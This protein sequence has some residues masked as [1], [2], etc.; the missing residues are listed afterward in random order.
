MGRENDTSLL[1]AVAYYNSNTNT[2][3]MV[4]ASMNKKQSSVGAVGPQHFKNC[5]RS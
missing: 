2:W 3:T 1:N 4:T 5:I